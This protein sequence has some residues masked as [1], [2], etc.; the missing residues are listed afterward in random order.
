M[1]YNHTHSLIGFL[2]SKNFEPRLN[3]RGINIIESKG[4]NKNE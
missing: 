2:P 1:I 3:W 4:G